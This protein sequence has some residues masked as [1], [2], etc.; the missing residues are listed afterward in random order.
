MKKRMIS[1]SNNGG[2]GEGK[3]KKNFFLKAFKN[4]NTRGEREREIEL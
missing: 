2:Q 3:E 1:F 4:L